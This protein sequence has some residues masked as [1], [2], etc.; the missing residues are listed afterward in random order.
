MRRYLLRSINSEAM[1]CF[2]KRRGTSLQRRRIDFHS[3][4]DKGA[5]SGN[6]SVVATTFSLYLEDKKKIFL[7][8]V[9]FH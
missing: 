7:S 5:S 6:P 9:T 2:E 3:Q 1:N 8:E 4:C